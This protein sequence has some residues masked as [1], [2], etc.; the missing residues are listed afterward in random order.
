MA[1]SLFGMSGGD[2]DALGDFRSGGIDARHGVTR[3]EEGDNDASVHD[4]GNKF[5]GIVVFHE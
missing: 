4:H 1:V 2:D 3:A 5:E